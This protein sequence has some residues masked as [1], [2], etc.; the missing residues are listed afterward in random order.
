MGINRKNL[1]LEPVTG[2]YKD[3]GSKFLAYAFQV[4]KETEIADYLTQLKKEHKTAR[5]WCYAWRL[6]ENAESQRISD[7]GEPA[8]SA[9][10]PIANVID[11]YDLSNILLV[12]VRYFGGV[13][14]GQRGL[15]DAYGGAALDALS[16][17]KIGP[18]PLDRQLQ[19]TFP[20]TL[21]SEVQKI[22]NETGLKPIQSLYQDQTVEMHFSADIAVIESAKTAFQQLYELTIT[23]KDEH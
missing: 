11:Q 14:L 18:M 19:I 4:Q 8:G 17:A 9:G 2:I 20:Y 12:V 15:I 7:D 23:E 22:I 6:G 10:R 5:H 13:L 3:K 1:L 16:Q 21:T